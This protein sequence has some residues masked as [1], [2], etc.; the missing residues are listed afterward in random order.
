M[1]ILKFQE[2]NGWKS[3]E[4]TM[5][6]SLQLLCPCCSFGDRKIPLLVIVVLKGKQI[7]RIGG[8]DWCGYMGYIDRP[9]KEWFKSFY[10]SNWDAQGRSE[11]SFKIEQLKALPTV[12]LA[13]PILVNAIAKVPNV[14]RSRPALVIGAGFGGELKQFQSIGFKEVVGTESSVHRAEVAKQA[15]GFDLMLGNFEELDFSGQGPYSVISHHHVLEHV[16]DPAEFIK[17]CASLQKVGDHMLLAMPNN[18][19]EPVMGILNFLPHL[20]SFTVVGLGRLLGNYDY[21]AIDFTMTNARNLNVVAV[22]RDSKRSVSIPV[23]GRMQ[24]GIQ[25]IIKGLDM[26]KRWID[27]PKRIVWSKMEDAA[28]QYNLW[29]R[30]KIR[31]SRSFVIRQGK[32]AF[33]LEVE[34]RG[35]VKM[36]VK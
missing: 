30:P 24:Y 9:T 33:P 7:I 36:M 10:E 6:L 12:N 8:C 4:M 20:H 15:F 11:Q 3:I 31:D 32:I 1:K 18:L 29:E 17:K 23:S 14:D 34:F 28:K 16:Y 19:G 13:D 5:P 2:L 25:K 35:N 21:E 27:T 26:K 22:K